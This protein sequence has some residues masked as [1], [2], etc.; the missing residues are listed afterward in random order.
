[1]AQEQTKMVERVRQLEAE[2]TAAGLEQLQ[3]VRNARIAEKVSA[4]GAAA[5]KML[6]GAQQEAQAR[7]IRAE[8][9]TARLRA[10]LETER[11]K[12]RAAEDAAAAG[13]GAGAVEAGV[14]VELVTLREANAA[15][16]E[17]V[18]ALRHGGDGALKE[19]AQVLLPPLPP[20]LLQQ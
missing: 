6:E 20:P 17:Q 5:L 9:E 18:Q 1:M 4:D 14:G 16:K 12:A 3:L 2:A 19:S 15:L 7:A 10:Q 11:G 13:A 8:Q